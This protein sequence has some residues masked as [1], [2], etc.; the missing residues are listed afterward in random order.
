MPNPFSPSTTTPSKTSQLPDAPSTPSQSL[1]IRHPLSLNRDRPPPDSPVDVAHSRTGLGFPDGD[2]DD[3]EFVDSF[4]DAY[5]Y[6]YGTAR[7]MRVQQTQSMLAFPT[8]RN[9]SDPDVATESRGRTLHHVASFAGPSSSSAEVFFSSPLNTAALVGAATKM[10]PTAEKRTSKSPLSPAYKEAYPFSRPMSDGSM[11]SS[12]Q[13]SPRESQSPRRPHP[14][15]ALQSAPVGVT[16]FNI[17]D[18]LAN[19]KRPAS[20]PLSAISSSS[21]ENE[22]PWGYF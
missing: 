7:T 9:V 4:A 10:S 1:L 6:E 12:G 3:D 14:A 11:K 22:K 19:A 17:K 8:L 21:S 16:T 15:A 20:M 2:E 5:A 18:K 13:D